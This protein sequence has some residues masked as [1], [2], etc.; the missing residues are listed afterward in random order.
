[1][2]IQTKG[3]CKYCGKEYTKPYMLRHLA[4]CKE[5]R[6]R[7]AAETGAK[8]C[9]CFELVIYGKYNKNY[10]LIIEMREDTTL[11]D[12]DSFLRDIWLECCGHLSAFDICGIRYEVFPNEESFWGEPAKSMDYELKSVFQKG[13][14]IDYEYD[15]GSSTDLVI[16][17]Y[18]YR[19][20]FWRKE[21]LT[22]LSRNNPPEFLCDECQGKAA[23]VICM[24]CMYDGDGFLCDDCR[25]THRCGEEMQ[26]PVCNSPRMGV[27]AYTGSDIYLDQFI[28]DKKED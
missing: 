15:F 25:E 20:S 6:A 7:I 13:M 10:W 9:G 4:S 5:R 28:P 11:K 19:E 8:R 3:K 21:K 1:M 14:E 16:K 27:C 2:G 18:D 22:I 23:S 17:V 26:L 12:L 24:E